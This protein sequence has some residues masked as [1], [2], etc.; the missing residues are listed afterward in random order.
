MLGCWFLQFR[1][2]LTKLVPQTS[3]SLAESDGM[4]DVSLALSG[5]FAAMTKAYELYGIFGV[6]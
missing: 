6:M 3:A 4:Y 2:C 5:L 1:Y